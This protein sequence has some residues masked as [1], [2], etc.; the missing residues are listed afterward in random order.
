MIVYIFILI[1]LVAGASVGY[2]FTA[3]PKSV[4]KEDTP[5]PIEDTSIVEIKKEPELSDYE[6]MLLEISRQSYN[7]YLNDLEIAQEKGYLPIHQHN[8]TVQQQIQAVE[9]KAKRDLDKQTNRIEQIIG[10]MKQNIEETEKHNENEYL[11]IMEEIKAINKDKYDELNKPRSE[12]D[13]CFSS[14]NCDKGLW[15]DVYKKCIKKLAPGENCR[16]NVSCQS[17]LCQAFNLKCSHDRSTLYKSKINERCREDDNCE[18]DNI[19]HPTRKRCYN[20]DP[21]LC[22]EESA[23]KTT[24]NRCSWG[25]G[26]KCIP[27]NV[28]LFNDPK[29][30]GRSITLP[31]QGSDL[32]PDGSVGTIKR[33]ATKVSVPEGKRLSEVKANPRLAHVF[34][35][36]NTYGTQWKKL[37]DFKLCDVM[38]GAIS[39][40]QHGIPGHCLVNKGG[41]CMGI[42]VGFYRDLDQKITD[43]QPHGSHHDENNKYVQRW[44][45]TQVAIEK[46]LTQN[47]F[48][49]GVHAKY[50]VGDKYGTKA[51]PNP[52]IV[53]MCSDRSMAK[54]ADNNECVYGREAR[55]LDFPFTYHL[56]HPDHPGNKDHIRETK[57]IYQIPT[58]YGLPQEDINQGIK[59]CPSIVRLNN[60][61]TFDS[62]AGNPKLATI[63][64]DGTHGTAITGGKF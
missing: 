50:F 14:R 57:E 6:K 26:K 29:D 41:D 49:D 25:D 45:P 61:A 38:Q 48:K 53:P 21:I 62:V 17:G 24:G 22:N 36:D 11:K 63:Y 37:Y 30:M 64:S 8:Y 39:G 2:Y 52:H 33:C 3:K 28:T 42:P 1:L 32:N 18:G 40:D 56:M 27:F 35:D 60:R 15:C 44:C 31:P 47:E 9:D 34:V 43:I 55:C 23:V 19:C 46:K 12:G 10:D 7:D 59:W 5:I 20:P 13:V 54:P 58:T 51:K 16:A 4:I